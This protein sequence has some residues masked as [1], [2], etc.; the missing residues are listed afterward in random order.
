MTDTNQKP[1]DQKPTEQK[2]GKAPKAAKELP[3]AEMQGN[4]LIRRK[5][6]G[7]IIHNALAE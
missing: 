6:N 2:P 4:V 1:E 7:T 3:G 5:E